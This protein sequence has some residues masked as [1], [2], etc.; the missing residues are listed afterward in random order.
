MIYSELEDTK[1]QIFEQLKPANVMNVPT[2]LN[3]DPAFCWIP[4]LTQLPQQSSRSYHEQCCVLDAIIKTILKYISSGTQCNARHILVLGK[5][6]SGK[7]HVSSIGLLFALNNGLN[8]YVTS[9]AARRSS[10]FRC[11]HI[12]RL[13]CIGINSKDDASTAAEKAVKKISEKPLKR[14]ILLSLDVLLIEEIGLISSELLTTI[15]IILQ[16]VRDSPKTFGGV[17]ILA[18]GDTNQLPSITGSDIFLSPSLL[19]SFDCHFLKFFVRMHDILGQHLLDCMSLKPI[20]QDDIQNIVEVLSRE[21][22]FVESWDKVTDCTVMKVFGKKEAERLA[23]SEY[24][25]K[26]ARQGRPFVEFHAEDEMCPQYANTWKTATPDV[27]K[28]LDNECREPRKL[29]LHDKCVL[30]LTVNLEQL[31][32]G[33]LCILAQLPNASDSS[34]LIFVAPTVEAFTQENLIRDRLFACW[35]T[36]RVPKVTGF[37]HGMGNLS[38]R[39]RQ[40]PFVNYVSGTCHKIMGDTFS[41]IATQVSVTEKK[42]NLWMASQLYVILSRVHQLKYVTFVGEK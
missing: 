30:K 25:N 36:K 8:C 20:L 42:Y 29:V 39:R 23:V 2:T 37:T 26:I 35:P 21:C 3:K 14:A 28:F 32:Q 10:H 38:V 16:L 41:K 31:S 5:P 19:F 18:N 34:I 4:Q 9:L 27:Q 6:G 1:K 13:F 11:E 12:H 7:S 40:L 22:T 33:Q 24:Q 17:L 15:D